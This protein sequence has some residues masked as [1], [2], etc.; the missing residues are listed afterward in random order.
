MRRP[1]DSFTNP[2]SSHPLSVLNF[3]ST[4]DR[5]YRG[6]WSDWNQDGSLETI[7][8][9][10]ILWMGIGSLLGLNPVIALCC[11]IPLFLV[12]IPWKRRITY[13]RIGYVK[14][15]YPGYVSV[16][17]KL[18]DFSALILGPA[19]GA[20]LNIYV[21]RV[22]YHGHISAVPLEL[23]GLNLLT[24]YGIVNAVF[25]PRLKS[26]GVSVLLLAVVLLTI[27]LEIDARWT[28]IFIGFLA[29]SNGL[30]KLRCFLRDYPV[31]ESADGE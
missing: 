24:G 6:W 22:V 20:V 2:I 21:E 14:F 11:G 8:G 17:T 9:A 7:T 18:R 19:V 25:Y 15:T 31:L 26:W 23:F 5:V 3:R 28:V 13:P 29:L 30:N 16:W 1:R 10:I 4:Q 27:Y 12:G